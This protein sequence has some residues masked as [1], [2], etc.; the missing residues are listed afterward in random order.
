V[1]ALIDFLSS[2]LSWLLDAPLFVLKSLLASV[3]GAFATL[4][5]AVPVPGFLGTAAAHFAAVPVGA[6][7][8]LSAFQVKFGLGVM[9]AAYVLRFAI[10]RIP[11]FG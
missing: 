10:R 3:V 2:A 8:S 9:A 7:W 11:F 6:V 1:D 4:L 5:N